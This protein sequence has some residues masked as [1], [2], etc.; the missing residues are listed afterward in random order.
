LTTSISKQ[1]YGGTTDVSK[2]ETVQATSGDLAGTFELDW[3]AKRWTSAVAYAEGDFPF[4]AEVAG[5]RYEL[6]SDGRFDEEDIS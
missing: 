5:K 3:E 2:T 4:I 6:Y 1:R